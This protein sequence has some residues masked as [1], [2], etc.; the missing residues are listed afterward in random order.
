MAKFDNLL[1][2]A[3]TQVIK[4]WQYNFYSVICNTA[5]I[6]VLLI[7]LTYFWRNI[8]SDK[9]VGYESKN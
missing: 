8:N 9:M 6:Y 1:S 7:Y 2:N 5:I 3:E 4:S